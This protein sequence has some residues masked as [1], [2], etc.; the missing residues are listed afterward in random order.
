VITNLEN[1]ILAVVADLGD[2]ISREKIP[3]ILAFPVLTS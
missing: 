2:V 1:R 3:E